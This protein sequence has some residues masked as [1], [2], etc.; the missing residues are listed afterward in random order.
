[1]S[2]VVE[3]AGSRHR[4]PLD[5]V[6][7]LCETLAIAAIPDPRPLLAGAAFFRDTLLPVV[8]LDALLDRPATDSAACGAFVVIDVEGRRAALAVKHVIGMSSEPADGID[9]AALLSRLL[10]EPERACDSASPM[11]VEP[12][13]AKLEAGYLLA[14]L[15]G[16]TCGFALPSV[17]RIHAAGQVVP[18][19]AG[20]GAMMMGV[21]AIGGRVVP[22]LDLATR[23]DLWPRLAGQHFIEFTSPSAGTFV[24]A[25]ERI[26]GMAAI[27]HESL[28]APPPGSLIGAVARDS[29]LGAELIWIIDAASI[30]AEAG[31]RGDAG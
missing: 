3:T 31:G 29:Q 1:M 28:I 18:A 15:A 7:E 19:P 9:L 2:L 8:P 6:I 23:L 14:E 11:R 13:A 26:V 17:I 5:C 16:Q 20:A 10:P 25:V 12:P 27:E 21:T 22:V 4:L 30:A 24:V